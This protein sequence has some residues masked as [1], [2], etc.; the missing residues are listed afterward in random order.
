L[1]LEEAIRKMTSL[2]ALSFRM[3][4]RG[5]LREG[6]FADIT[7]FDPDTVRDTATFQNPHQYP[8]GIHSV[9]VN[10]QLVVDREKV[11]DKLPGM[12][13]YGPGYQPGEEAAS[14]AGR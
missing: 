13:I 4:D 10:G 11:T 7:I 8:R 9:L 1:T 3:K 2:P 6:Y 14:Y 5:L 12:P